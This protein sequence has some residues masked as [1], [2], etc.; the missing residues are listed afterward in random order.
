A[1]WQPPWGHFPSPG[2]GPFA[3]HRC[4]ERSPSA[5]A[6]PPPPRTTGLQPTSSSLPVADAVDGPRVIVAHEH[7][8]V[9]EHEEVHRTTEI[10]VVL[11]EAGHERLDPRTSLAVGLG[12]RDV[13]ILLG[14]VPRTVARDEHRTLVLGREHLAAIE[15]QAQGGRM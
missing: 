8:A 15:R 10:A 9:L 13:R 12:H 7:R 4:A 6:P 11:D 5:P 2:L 3:A 1:R 14:A